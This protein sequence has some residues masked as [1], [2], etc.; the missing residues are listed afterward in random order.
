MTSHHWNQHTNI[1]KV[2]ILKKKN[3][4]H[5][6]RSNQT[7]GSVCRDSETFLATAIASSLKPEYFVTRQNV[8]SDTF[9]WFDQILKVCRGR[10]ANHWSGGKRFYLIRPQ[11]YE[12]C[13]FRHMFKCYGF[14]VHYYPTFKKNIKLVQFLSTVVVRFTGITGVGTVALIWYRIKF[15]VCLFLFSHTGHTS[16]RI[17][18]GRI[19]FVRLHSLRPVKVVYFFVF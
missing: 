11:S 14:S 3:P 15:H 18:H 1:L 4:I 10:K 13:R 2:E 5:R 19:R 12:Q 8:C 16:G 7:I 6:V 17:A 9:F